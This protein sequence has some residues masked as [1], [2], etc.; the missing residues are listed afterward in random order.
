[1]SRLPIDRQPLTATSRFARPYRAGPPS[2][3]ASRDTNA[4]DVAPTA[5]PYAPNIGRMTS[6][7]GVGIDA[8]GSPIC[9]HAMNP[10]LSTSS[11]FTPKNAGFHN[12]RSASF[13][14]STEPISPAT[15]CAIAGL[16]VYLAM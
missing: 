16:I 11:G 6:G 8:F 5:R 3:S 15:P 13:P 1:M 2:S 7:C 10:P 14:T 9:A 12:T 4:T